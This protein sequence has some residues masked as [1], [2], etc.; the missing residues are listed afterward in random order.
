MTKILTLHTFRG[1]TGKTTLTATLAVLLA[2]SGKRVG[3]VD[4]DILSPG[5]HVMFGRF[6]RSIVCTIND[7]LRNSC[8]LEQAVVDISTHLGQDEGIGGN[9]KLFLLPASTKSEEI[10]RMYQ[11]GY[12]A[13]AL[14]QILE[15]FGNGFNLD[16]LLV[17]THTG[18]HE[19]TLLLLSIS[20]LMLIL[21][22][23]DQQDYEGTWE[24]IEVLRALGVSNI[25]LV[26]NKVP[27]I[28]DRATVES[29]VQEKFPIPVAAVIPHAD[30][31][32]ILGS[33]EVFALR[34]PSHPI[35]NMLRHIVSRYLEKFDGE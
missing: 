31:M 6:Q 20:S 5:L 33:Q 24:T 35:T 14:I 25:L 10:T 12:D 2:Q 29:Q 16:L 3:V 26:V 17:D 11:S 4:A 19:N 15:A 7:V 28:F 34:Y 9:G 8:T 32:M 18:L 23:P 1:G 27:T 13:D 21:M 22:R 30:E